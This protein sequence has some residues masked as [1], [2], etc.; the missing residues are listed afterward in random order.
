MSLNQPDWDWRA[1]AA[2]VADE[3][4]V[5]AAAREQRNEPPISEVELFRNSGLLDLALADGSGAAGVPWDVA[6]AVVREIAAADGSLAVILGRHYLGSAFASVA[7][8]A[9]PWKQLQRDATNRKLLWGTITQ[10]LGPEVLAAPDGNLFVINAAKGAFGGAAIADVLLV[11]A[12]VPNIGRTIWTAIAANRSEL[13]RTYDADTVGVRTAWRGNVEV[14]GTKVEPDQ[15]ITATNLSERRFN[16]AIDLLNANVYLGSGWG[17]FKSAR[18]YTL[19]NARP[20]FTT[21]IEKATAD[22]YILQRYG[23]FW[24]ILTAADALADQAANRFQYAIDHPES[25]DASE[26]DAIAALASAAKIFALRTGL[27]IA[28]GLYDV[29][30]GVRATG[31][32]YGLD[33]YWR[34]IRTYSLFE[35]TGRELDAVCQL[36]LARHSAFPNH[37]DKRPNSRSGSA[38]GT[39]RA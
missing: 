2:E 12:S 19:H 5:G 24:T 25:A 36:L 11:A 9:I 37:A 27:E 22:P 35:E 20:Y 26:V 8:V 6:L 15:I 4:R 10:R 1:K 28:S 21:G 13:L 18:H 23:D 17:A 16:S 34:D 33:R 31:L 7:G 29:T 30:G 38:S 14:T 32:E 3:L 39:S